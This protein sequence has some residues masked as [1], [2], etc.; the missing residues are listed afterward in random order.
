VNNEK[1][2]SLNKTA[3]KSGSS[4]LLSNILLRSSALLTAPIFTRLLSTSDYGIAGNFAAWL[5]IGL[6]IVGLGLPYSI[7]NAKIDFPS[8]F[9]KYLASIQILGSIVGVSVLLLA[10]LFRVQLSEWMELDQYLVV[11]LFVYLLF[12]P[13]V[14]FSQERYKFLLLYKENIYISIFSTL[15]SIVFCLIF[16]LYVFSEERYYGRIIGLI[17]PLFLMGVFFYNK[18]LRDGWSTNIRK[19]W[20][21]ALKI[22]V[23]MIPHALAMVVLDQMDRIMIIK[24][25]G[26]SVAGLYSF[27]Y[28]YAILILIFSNAVLQAYNPWLYISYLKNDI[29]AIKTSNMV[30]T[31]VMCILTV[32]VVSMAPEALKLLG[33]RSFW[34][35]KWV[36]APIAAGALFQYVYN[37]YASL[38]LYHKKTTVIAI[39][40]VLAAI[41]NYALNSMFIPV[42][43]YVA[44]AYSTFASYFVL[45]LFHRYA[46]QKVCKKQVYDDKY[47]FAVTIFTAVISLLITQLYEYFFLRYLLLVVLLLIVCFS[48][49]KRIKTLYNLLSSKNR[50]FDTLK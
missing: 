24:I 32:I 22:S 49:I 29:K 40:S 44:A 3:I 43:G 10:I 19:Y 6:V 4:Y 13:S 17:L 20:S 37:T 23:P 11:M 47:V 21:Y 27:G 16:I 33:S 28:G 9:N 46:C 14:V 36:I 8:E 35:A 18:I 34:D 26:R 42:F 30:I 39:G 12:L 5:S 31:Y 25:C 38:E 41:I 2:S 48:Q 7:G 50:N 1:S 15:G 45:A